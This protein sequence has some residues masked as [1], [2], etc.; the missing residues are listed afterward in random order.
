MS[1]VVAGASV[2][3]QI[4]RES[5]PRVTSGGS[6]PLSVAAKMLRPGGSGQFALPRLTPPAPRG[7][8]ST[9]LEPVPEP[10]AQTAL[11]S[12][13]AARTAAAAPAV[14]V[15]QP[16]SQRQA[17][18]QPD[19]P[20]RTDLR[21]L[22]V[23]PRTVRSARTVPPVGPGSTDLSQVLPIIST[24]QLMLREYNGSLEADGVLGPQTRA[25]ILNFQRNHE[26]PAT[27]ALAEDDWRILCT[28]NTLSIGCTGYGVQACQWLLNHQTRGSRLDMDGVFGTGTYMVVRDA[29]RRLGMLEDGVVDAALWFRLLA[30]AG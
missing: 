3:G 6:T 22:H 15:Y 1:V 9:V 5:T 24:A 19:S 26:R 2:F 23:Q 11:A 18:P 28:R 29:Q 7:T 21:Q 10:R 17:A 12:Q 16:P 13:W 25:A 30:P 20:R 4:A 14:A 8:G 27:G